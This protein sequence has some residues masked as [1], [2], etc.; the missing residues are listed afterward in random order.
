MV[1]LDVV[2]VC[3]QRYCSHELASGNAVWSATLSIATPTIADN[4]RSQLMSVISIKQRIGLL[5][6]EADKTLT[7]VLWL[8]LG[9]S[10]L[11][12]SWHDTW[13]EALLIGVPAASVPFILRRISEPG[14]LYTRLAVAV[15]LMVFSALMIHQARG[16]LE[17]HFAI[18]CFLAFLLY[19]RDWKPIVLAAVVIAVHHVSFYF[20]QQNQVPVFAYPSTD[21]FWIVL[22]HAA[23]VVAETA[24][25][26]L[27]SRRMRS[28]TM[29]AASVAMLAETIGR[30]D[31]ATR[32]EPAEG[33][34]S[35]L[36]DSVVAMQTSLA[37]LIGTVAQETGTIKGV[38]S[39][40]S[41][42]SRNVK[43]QSTRQSETSQLMAER[44]RSLA[45]SVAQSN[46]SAQR[47]HEITA[48][49]EK[50]SAEGSRV[51]ASTM[52]EIDAM[53]GTIR[54]TAQRIE[55]LGVATDQVAGIVSV[56]QA[57]AEQTNLLALNAAI[58]AARAGE[59]GRGFAVV[60]DEV[61]KLA[62]RTAQA[63]TEIQQVIQG[64]QDSKTVAVSSMA[65][66][67]E[68]VSRGVE[69]TSEVQQSISAI[70]HSAHEAVNM[71]AAIADGLNAQAEAADA[72]GEQVGQVAD[73]AREND[74][75]VAR[76]AVLA[77]NID[78][79]VGRIQD[80]VGKL[81]VQ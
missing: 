10:L 27:F 45:N 71:V 2:T 52:A 61:R 77:V 72:I 14:A 62:E 43:Q 32:I 56:I 24:V 23:F 31:L 70:T 57:I 29:E 3:H 74:G 65:D 19:Y 54:D 64:I 11:L 33:E 73:A 16:M 30:G 75:L 41:T 15:S 7:V 46:D 76:V 38:C 51:I 69:L 4:K 22:L 35:P 68:S 67:V 18:F 42:L 28:E 20:M 63:T 39:E 34:R 58:E 47:A 55:Q 17:F 78:A 79:T 49:T 5:R 26:L 21:N 40:L 48:E 60:A 13:L 44:A 81:K 50:V 66:M 8:L 9:V 59:Q 12:A 80:G 53:A 37:D 6:G 25:L 36:F 1:V